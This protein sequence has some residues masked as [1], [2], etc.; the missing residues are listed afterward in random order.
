MAKRLSRE[1]A[2]TGEVVVSL[3][4]N[5]ID[6]LD[7]RVITPSGETIFYGHKNSICAGELD[8]DMN[9]YNYSKEPVENIFWDTAPHGEYEVRCYGS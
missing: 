4:W 2:K 9:C 5:N 3:M 1:G 6:D 7:L 8:V